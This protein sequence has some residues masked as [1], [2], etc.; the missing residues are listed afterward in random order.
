MDSPADGSSWKRLLPMLIRLS[1]V[2]CRYNT[3]CLSEIKLLGSVS[4]KS[5]YLISTYGQYFAGKI[6]PLCSKTCF[7]CVMS[8]RSL[9]IMYQ[10]LQII[11]N[12]TLQVDRASHIMPVIDHEYNYNSWM[13]D[14][15]LISLA[16][17]GIGASCQSS[18]IPGRMIKRDESATC[19]I[20]WPEPNRL[21]CVM[22][23]PDVFR[24]HKL[25]LRLINPL[26]H[27]QNMYVCF[28]PIVWSLPC[29]DFQHRLRCFGKD[30]HDC[31]QRHDSVTKLAE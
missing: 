26:M 18:K 7:V 1:S 29:Y 10:N 8:T 28:L 30:S 9:G 23:G 5:W 19:G 15:V 6:Q 25:R 14:G 17:A 21:I 22:A 20:W 4:I 27:V 2:W 16:W 12:I 24:L 31:F 13:T 11:S 3:R